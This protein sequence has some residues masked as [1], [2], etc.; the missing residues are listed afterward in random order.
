MFCFTVK[1][2]NDV[3]PTL[4]AFY[5]TEDTANAAKVVQAT[6]FPD[7]ELGIVTEEDNDYPNRYPHVMGLVTNSDGS[8]D[9]LWSDS[10]RTPMPV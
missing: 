7:A 3:R 5:D 1:R 9:H 8:V 4:C 2:E 10:V 6:L